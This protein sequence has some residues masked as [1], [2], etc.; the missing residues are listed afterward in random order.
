MAVRPAV[1]QV[2]SLPASTQRYT[3][4]A[5]LD[6][7][8]HT[9]K[10][11]VTL[12]LVNTA[13]APLTAL[14]F[15]LY[16][17]AFRDRETV[18]MRESGGQLRGD[19]YRSPGSIELAN[20]RVEGRDLL[21]LSERELVKNDRTQ[22]RVPLPT[23]LK[24][25]EKA[26]IE[27]EFVSHLPPVFAR[28]GYDGDFYAV[29]QWFP[30]LAKLEHDGTFTS[31]A[32]HAQGEFYADFADYTL[33]VDTPHDYIVGACGEL[34]DERTAGQ[35]TLRRY[36]AKSVHDMA[37]VASPALWTH[38]E[39]I[40]NVD[41]RV[42]YPRGYESALAEHTDTVRAG[43]EH[44]GKQFGPY[45]YPTLTVVIPPRTAEGAAGME[46]PTMIL[47]AGEWLT[48]SDV[49][50]RV[51]GAFV[52]AHELAHEWFYGLVATNEVRYPA[53]DEGFTEWASL[54]LLRT[55]YGARAAF[56][57]GY[58]LDVFELERLGS[59]MSKA[60]SGLAA[61]AFSAREYG[62]SVYAR[63]AVALESIRRAHGKAR[64]ERAMYDYATS[65]R[66]A[67][68]GPDELGASFDEVYGAGFAKSTVLP[69]VLGG[70]TSAVHLV[71]ARTGAR[72]KQYRTRVKA[73]RTGSVALPTWIA[74]YDHQG[75]ELA[76]TAFPAQVAALEATFDTNVPVARV[77]ADPDRA[78]L[79]DPDAR[80]QTIVF[81]GR[82]HPGLL[83]RLL[84]LIGLVL[85]WVGP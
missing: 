68:P 60:P 66:F 24:P 48:L 52:T 20:L 65:Q 41:V 59:L 17:N 9:V 3:L 57:F 63:T 11:K 39:R 16:L 49:P 7:A 14:V 35:R 42:L 64:F 37:F 81:N 74:V 77:V 85:S 36:E 75:R 5:R 61:Y 43:L 79:V 45:P 69:L 15:H 23:P 84:G 71:E 29:A 13:E 25:G 18:F 34:A 55:Q 19:R 46:Y 47:S 1:A 4:T 27:S 12:S 50:P 70:Q 83:T 67:H 33:T 32:Y 72:E 38:R 62:A 53:L 44:F 40:A 78:L 22:L 76:R 58:P 6:P 56:A 21:P 51:T 26:L 82:S 73:R 10:G 28:A 54:D 2:P 8:T 80:D 31:F 30:K